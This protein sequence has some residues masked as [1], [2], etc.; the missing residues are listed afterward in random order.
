MQTL[1][2][3]ELLKMKIINNRSVSD[4][5]LVEKNIKDVLVNHSSFERIDMSKANITATRLRDCT[6]NSIRF[7]DIVAVSTVLRL[8]RFKNLTAIQANFHH[9]K[10]ENCVIQGAD[11]SKTNFESTS[12]IESDFSRSCFARTNLASADF[13]GSNLRGVDFRFA[14]VINTSFRGADLRGAD[15]SGAQIES[16]DFTGADLRG[17]IFD[18]DVEAALFGAQKSNQPPTELIDAVS[19]IVASL[20]KQAERNG[21]VSD[22]KW[23]AELQQTLATM[24]A[25]PLDENTIDLW[26]QQVSFWLNQA[27]KIGVNDLLESLRSDDEKPPAAIVPMLEGFIKELGLQPGTSTQELVEVLFAKL[28]KPDASCDK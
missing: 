8:C 15:F 1:A 16:A 23:R 14:V 10:I 19:P 9:A 21:A 2:G 7:N 25:S 22:D 13:E 27:G 3:E 28:Q 18:T 26:D 11:F 4:C 24:G 6:L 20:L 12:L 17:A 5:N